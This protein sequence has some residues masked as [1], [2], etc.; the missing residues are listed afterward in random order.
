MIRLASTRSRYAVAL[1]RPS[2]SSL[3]VADAPVF[4]LTSH[5]RLLLNAPAGPVAENKI[6]RRTVRAALA[7]M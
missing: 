5:V 6:G 4:G 3:T 1:Y 7:W 2:D